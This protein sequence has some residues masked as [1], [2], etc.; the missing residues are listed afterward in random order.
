MKLGEII[1]D[2]R[3]VDVRPRTA[4]DPVARIGR[5]AVE[6]ALDAQVGAPRPRSRSNRRREALTSRISA[7]QSAEIPRRALLAR[8]E[9]GHHWLRARRTRRVVVAAAGGSSE[10][11]GDRKHHDTWL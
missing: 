11:E 2:Q 3:A 4:A 9:K 5:P 10:D 6:V 1:R 8:H 7:A